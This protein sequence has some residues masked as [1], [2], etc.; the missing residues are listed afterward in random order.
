MVLPCSSPSKNVHFG[1]VIVVPAVTRTVKTMPFS[2]CLNGNSTA[3]RALIASA[4]AYLR[5]SVVGTAPIL[6]NTIV[7]VIFE[8]RLEDS[9][10][11]KLHLIAIERR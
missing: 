4:R 9:D 7:C 6:N 3:L 11:A 5:S 2:G 1:G 8:V 10:I